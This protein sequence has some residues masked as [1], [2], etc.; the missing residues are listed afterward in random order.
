MKDFKKTLFMKEA[1]SGKGHSA[2]V[3]ILIAFVLLFISSVAMG[4]A[5]L[6]VL[7]IYLVNNK[8]YMSMLMS[9]KMDSQKML[10]I[11]SNMPE[12]VMIDMLFAEILLTLIVILYCRIVEKRKLLTLGFVKDKMAKQYLLGIAFGA[13]A[14]SVAYLICVVT[15]SVKFEG[16]AKDTTPL[17]ILGFFF[18]YLL[19]GMAEEVLCRGY[20]MVSLS[21]K[22]HVK[23]AIISSS[24]FFAFLHA[25]NNGF[26][27][28]A[29]INLFLFGVFASLLLLVFGNIWIAGAFH[30]IWNF[31]QGN[32][33]GIKVSGTSASSSVFLTSNTAG[34]EIINGGSFG[35]E[36]GIAVT[37]VLVAGIS[38]L[39]LHLYKRGDI[40]DITEQ[41]IE[42]QEFAEIAGDVLYKQDDA[43]TS[44][45]SDNHIT[46]NSTLKTVFDE[47]YFKE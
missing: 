7:V 11:M 22:Y 34:R 44:H 14:F 20:L 13:A 28:L 35:M 25:S 2:L 21:R 27:L 24:L 18:G 26:S 29:F 31:V 10:S 6:P 19:Q 23:Q 47:N 12:W 43:N 46:D 39:L 32:I 45:N 15:G 4:I 40:I 38:L 8:D 16:I 36:G 41:Q 42:Q 1:E 30:S 3:E 9:G 17:Y 33:Y 5:Q 37:F